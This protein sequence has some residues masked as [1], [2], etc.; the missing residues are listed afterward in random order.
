MQYRQN[1]AFVAAPIDHENTD[2]LINA[3][4]IPRVPVHWQVKRVFLF[5]EGIWAQGNLR[6]KADL[7]VEYVLSR[8]SAVASNL[9]KSTLCALF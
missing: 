8:Y 4:V 2:S 9:Q 6:D 5:R 1:Q 3:H 7:G